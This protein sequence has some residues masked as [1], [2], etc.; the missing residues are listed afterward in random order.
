MKRLFVT[1]GAIAALAA[2]TPPAG[3]D[4]ASGTDPSLKAKA[5][6][7]AGGDERFF[8]EERFTIVMAHTGQQTGVS[9]L[10]VR[11]WG[12]KRAEIKDLTI[13]FAGMTQPMRERVINEGARI[14]TIDPT[15][16][17]GSATDNPLYADVVEAMRGRDGVAF[18]AEIMTRMG[19]RRTGESGTFAGHAC[20]Y[21]EVAQLGTR[22]CVTPW[23]GTLRVSSALAGL[24]IEQTATEVR[25][26]DGGPDDAFAYDPSKVT[27][28]P[29]VGDILDKM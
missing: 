29:D 6:G 23:G 20:D 17:A 4:S 15:S 24:T 14:I 11:E 19:G 1:L 8:G 26:G 7:A 22:S 5:A 27:A 3:Q 28:A 13:N 16:G 21:W 18:G 12:R 9:T 10:H 25:L 2:C